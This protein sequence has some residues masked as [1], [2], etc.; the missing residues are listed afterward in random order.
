MADLYD[1]AITATGTWSAFTTDDQPN[2]AFPVA[3]HTVYLTL[4]TRDMP[5][6]PLHFQVTKLTPDE[7]SLIYMERGG[8][9]SFTKVE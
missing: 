6:E 7:L 5:D 1:G 4:T 3:P 2:V 8:T 9:L